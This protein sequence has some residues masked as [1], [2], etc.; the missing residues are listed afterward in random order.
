VSVTGSTLSGLDWR[1]AQRSVG[2]GPCVEVAHFDDMV[3]M[4]DSKDP[5]GHVLIYTAAEWVEFLAGA[6]DGDFDD[7]CAVPSKVPRNIRKIAERSNRVNNSHGRHGRRAEQFIP[8]NL[9]QSAHWHLNQAVTTPETME[10]YLR[11]GKFFRSTLCTILTLT[12]IGSVIFGAGVAAAVMAAGMP[13]LAAVSVGAGGISLFML[14]AA[15]RIY[16]ALKSGFDLLAV[17]GPA[18]QKHD[19]EPPERPEGPQATG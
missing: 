10:R 4:R 2:N 14:P 11:V 9:L 15:F 5:D 19:L 7:V 18:R 6:K 17:P 16:K 1:K 12:L 3:A 8:E 13:P